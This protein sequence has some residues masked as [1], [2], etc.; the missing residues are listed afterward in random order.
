L[1]LPIGPR[2]YELAE[3]KLAAFRKD[4]DAWRDAAIDTDFK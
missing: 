2:A 4:M 3:R 1:H